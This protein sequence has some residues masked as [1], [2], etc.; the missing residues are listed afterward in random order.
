MN[1]LRQYGH[2]FIQ[3][4][5]R[6]RL[7]RRGYVFLVCLA[8][9]TALWL[10]IALSKN[11]TTY[12]DFPVKYIN[13]PSDQVVVNS[14]PKHLSLEV[15]AGGF[16]LLGYKWF[17][18]IRTI[19]LDVGQYEADRKQSVSVTSI[20]TSDFFDDIAKQLGRGVN[21]DRDYIFPKMIEVIT[22]D[23]VTKTLA[24][25]PRHQL[26]FG[27]GYRLS[28][29][30]E[31][32]PAVVDVFGPTCL[33]DTIESLSTE[34]VQVE[35]LAESQMISAAIDFNDPVGVLKCE[36][37]QVLMEIPVDQY[38]LGSSEVAITVEGLPDSIVLQL[39]PGTIKVEYLVGMRD[40][41]QVKG[42][43]FT[44][45]VQFPNLQD[46]VDKLKVHL[47]N[48]PDLVEVV[49]FEPKKVQFVWRKKSQ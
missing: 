24:I 21:I 39:F 44:A 23:T 20:S 7:D 34:L 43:M 16:T 4:A 33:L 47:S 32:R 12:L 22:S 18:N 46:S 45:E 3:S 29:V 5:L 30:V 27:E 9:S 10:L 42:N 28:G 17:K 41:D 49:R 48:A 31:A 35:A 14:L 40:Y 38:T 36:Q 2:N 26:Q 8:I 15:T 1:D 6:Y 37:A 25:I 19:K 13:V 11:Y